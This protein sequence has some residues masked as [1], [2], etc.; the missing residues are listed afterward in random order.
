M[1]R[2]TFARLKH[3]NRQRAAE[4]KDAKGG[5][6]L[7]DW[8]ATDLGCALA[9][10]VGELC[11]L[12]KKIRRGDRVDFEAVADELADVVIY[13]DILAQR[14]GIKLGAAVVK[15]FNQTSAKVGAQTRL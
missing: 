8:S 12:L 9:G 13:A 5:D 14:L 4:W 1:T 3:A 15:K 7:R 11:N 6:V 2:L 10:E